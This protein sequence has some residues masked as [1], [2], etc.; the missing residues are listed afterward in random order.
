M[1]EKLPGS[2]NTAL[3]WHASS[4]SKI[5][6]NTEPCSVHHTLGKR[7]RER[8]RYV[9]LSLYIQA[10]HLI[11]PLYISIKTEINAMSLHRFI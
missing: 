8:E 7:E 6:L 1:N 3:E 4:S 9:G 5:T 10:P 2:E 11:P